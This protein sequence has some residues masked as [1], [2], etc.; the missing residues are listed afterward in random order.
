MAKG[1]FLFSVHLSN[2][3]YCFAGAISSPLRGTLGALVNKNNFLVRRVEGRSRSVYQVCGRDREGRR[4]SWEA[5]VE[6]V[7]FEVFPERCDR[8]TVSYL[9]GERV[10]K[11]WGI[12]TKRI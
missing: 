1:T 5:R 11:N 2:L 3:I 8:G 6:Q 12:V 7:G 9:K 4:L 10:P